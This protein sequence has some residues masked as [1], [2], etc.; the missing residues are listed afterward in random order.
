M[1][2]NPALLRSSF[3]LVV[4]RNPKLTERFYE[5]FFQRYPQVK[6]LFGR[7]SQPE[8][9]KM[10]AEALAG[11]LDHLDDAPWLTSTLGG[12]GVKHVGYG[13]TSEMY[14]WVG[15]CLLAAIAEAAGPAWN[16]ELEQAWTDAYGA[17]AGLMQSGARGAA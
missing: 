4:E 5:I 6:P 16:K 15:E 14:G 17:V 2:L 9:A 13:V 3:E 11:V 1:A 12:M 8:Q 10:L 7:R